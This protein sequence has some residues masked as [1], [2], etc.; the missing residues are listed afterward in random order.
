MHMITGMVV[1]FDDGRPPLNYTGNLSK[2]HDKYKELA[3]DYDLH[4]WRTDKEYGILYYD[5]KKKVSKNG[6]ENR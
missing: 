5:A 2:C 6:V 3:Y 4:Y 1:R